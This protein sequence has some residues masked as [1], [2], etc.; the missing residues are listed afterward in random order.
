MANRLKTTGFARF[1]I[2]LLIAA[3]VIYSGVA[4]FNG[5]NPIDS[6]KRDLGISTTTNNDS[7]ERTAG[8]DKLEA[9]MDDLKREVRDLESD[10]K[11]LKKELAACQ[12]SQRN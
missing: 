5:E 2:F 3:P 7:A 10:I 8:A 6:A 11:S 1:F 4:L 12:A 9:S